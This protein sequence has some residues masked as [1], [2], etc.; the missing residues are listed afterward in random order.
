MS[1]VWNDDEELVNITMT[2]DSFVGLVQNGCLTASMYELKRR[3][4]NNFK[5]EED[6]QWVKLK[7]ES[8]KAYGAI[9][10]LRKYEESLYDRHSRIRDNSNEQD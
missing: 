1:T 7:E 8:K 9:K 5:L 4:L 3:Y 10:E 6:P 2:W